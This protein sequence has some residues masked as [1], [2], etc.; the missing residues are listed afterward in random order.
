M[1]LLFGAAKAALRFRDYQ[2]QRVTFGSVRSWLKQFKA[3]DQKIIA[4]LLDHIIYFSETQT[5]DILVSQNDALLT[6]LVKAKVSLKN[7]IYMQMHDAGSS[8]PAM[9]STLKIAGRLERLGCKFMDSH[10][11]L[12]LNEI[13]NKLG[14]GVIIYVDDFSGSGDQFCGARDFAY[15]NVI[16]NFPEFLLVPCVCEEAYRQ[17]SQKG[18]EVVTGYI[19][20]KA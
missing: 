1:G 11:S 12:G 2:P 10:D 6:R 18:I 7:I 4:T 3:P 19:H 8:S 9:L 14:E 15:E 5:R 13:T 20:S 16:G 17:V